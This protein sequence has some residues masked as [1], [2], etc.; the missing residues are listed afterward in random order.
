V[1]FGQTMKFAGFLQQ[2]IAD[3]VT[4]RRAMREM[5]LNPDRYNKVQK[6]LNKLREAAGSNQAYADQL[7]CKLQENYPDSESEDLETDLDR[8]IADEREQMLKYLGTLGVRKYAIG[9]DI[10]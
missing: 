10:N 2:E 4:R 9:G 1:D 7:Y 6:Q 8:M 5:L 3:P